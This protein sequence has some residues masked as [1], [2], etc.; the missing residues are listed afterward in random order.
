[1]NGRRNTTEI[2]NFASWKKNWTWLSCQKIFT[3]VSDNRFFFL[4]QIEDIYEIINPKYE[5]S[6][7]EAVS[8]ETFKNTPEVRCVAISISVT[9][10]YFHD[11]FQLVGFLSHVMTILA[12]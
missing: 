7:R 9:S 11:G 5:Y 3:G 12:S 4:N 1:M 6:H 8:K 2:H 10:L